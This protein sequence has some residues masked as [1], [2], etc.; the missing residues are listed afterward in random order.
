VSQ[1]NPLCFALIGKGGDKKAVKQTTLMSMLP[2]PGATELMKGAKGKKGDASAAPKTKSRSHE[3]GSPAPLEVPGDEEEETQLVETLVEE[4]T[5]VV[6][7]PMD[8]GE[9]GGDEDEEPIEWPESP[10]R[11]VLVS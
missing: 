3:D 10:P 2:L 11:E 9:G 7:E 5:Q 6:D 1:T 8:E 4:E